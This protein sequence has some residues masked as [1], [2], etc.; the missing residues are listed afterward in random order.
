MINENG[1]CVTHQVA[2]FARTINISVLMS[3][4]QELA[5]LSRTHFPQKP[6][7]FPTLRLLI[8]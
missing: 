8:A 4:R 1:E 5:I 2:Y 3:E 6:G 7:C